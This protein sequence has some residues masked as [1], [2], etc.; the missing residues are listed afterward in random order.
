MK[1]SCKPGRLLRAPENFVEPA[2]AQ[3]ITQDGL[4][5]QRR[6]FLRKSFMAASAAVG[7]A[8]AG[9][10][11]AQ[12]GD[13]DPAILN[14]PAHSTTLHCCPEYLSAHNAYS[15]ESCRAAI[16]ACSALRRR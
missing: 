6:G 10:A 5:Q 11:M 3:E 2:L 12:V 16:S 9:R 14:L 4:N 1:D 8:A 7:A 15:R 13:G